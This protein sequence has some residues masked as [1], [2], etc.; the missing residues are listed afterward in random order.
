MSE[1][2]LSTRIPLPTSFAT[3]A[4]S[5]LIG[6]LSLV[7]IAIYD[8]W[9]S[10][11]GLAARAPLI[12]LH[13]IF[14]ITFIAI[15]FIN[16]RRPLSGHF[17]LTLFLALQILLFTFGS[18][19]TA[20]TIIFFVLSGYAHESLPRK[21]ADMWILAY[22]IITMVGF[23]I[24]TNDTQFG[25]LIGLC[26]FGGYAFIGN[27]SRNRRDA[28]AA[29]A[30]SQRL[31]QELQI[32]HQQLQRY[33][34]EA[35]ILAAAEERN[36]LARELHDTL[37]H[38]LTVAAV[39]LEGAQRLI[40]RDANKATQMVEVVRAQVRD[41]LTELRQTVATL[42]TPIEADRALPAAI[43]TLADQYTAATALQVHVQISEAAMPHLDRLSRGARHTLYRA[44]QE[45]LTNIQ[46]HAQASIAWVQ[47]ALLDEAHNQPATIQLTIH[48][49]GIGIHHNFPHSQ[50]T[51]GFGLSGLS[52]RTAKEHGNMRLESSPY[53]G[54]ALI[55]ELPLAQVSA[56]APN[57][58]YAR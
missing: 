6:I 38:R 13:T 26:S 11:P 24:L 41:G 46:K 20:Q 17:A 28:E 18:S 21:H 33:A 7:A 48:D 29:R 44:T 3:Y 47:L 43:T 34:H 25:I 42:R 9:S 57:T 23:A 2:N 1:S 39:Q 45:G 40:H 58:L 37:G 14:F 16:L 15:D 27:A 8:V 5:E 51:P 36:R 12:I 19:P 55:I 4:K 30:E 22:G 52:E 35:E 53:G 56:I 10:P 49:N 54:N 31:L 32:A 50:P